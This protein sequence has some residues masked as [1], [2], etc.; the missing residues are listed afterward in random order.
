M[1]NI[2]VSSRLVTVLSLIVMLLSSVGLYA[3]TAH[4]VSQ[5]AKEIGI[6][7]AI[8]AKPAQIRRLVLRSA[9]VQ[10]ALGLF[11]GVLCTF[12]W[13]GAFFT[14][15]VDTRFADVRVLGP[16]AS[17]FAIVLLTACLAPT[18]RATRLDPVA[19]LRED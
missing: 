11:F 8:G 9:A 3:V 13:D 12:A 1:W 7:I 16:V 15:R 6:R 5:R 19:T 2:R 14:D 17:I 10:V 18:R 4:A